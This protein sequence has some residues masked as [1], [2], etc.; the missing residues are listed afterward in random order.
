MNHER[1]KR[2]LINPYCEYKNKMKDEMYELI[3]NTVEEIFNEKKYK[4]N[5][6]FNKYNLPEID[7]S[8]KQ[9]IR[10]IKEDFKINKTYNNYRIERIC[11]NLELEESRRKLKELVYYKLK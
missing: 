10:K 4:N 5:V 9:K 2:I 6:F 8:D 11:K 7:M 1:G 3:I